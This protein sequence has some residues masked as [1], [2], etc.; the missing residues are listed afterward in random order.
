VDYE[1]TWEEPV[2]FYARF[3]GWVTPESAAQVAL[4][5]A[6]DPRYTDLRYAIIDLT[7]APGHTFRRDDRNE[8]ANAMVQ[9]IGAG[10][11]NRWLAEIAVATDPKMLNFLSTYASLTNRPFYVF[12]SLPEARRWLALHRA[13]VLPR[14]A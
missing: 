10:M 11:S 8:V 12:D 6:S 7:D 4:E 1:I 2:G 14:I 13:G 3:T 9:A 5:L